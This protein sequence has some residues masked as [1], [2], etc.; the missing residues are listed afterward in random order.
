MHVTD[1]LDPLR[2]RM[3]RRV[4]GPWHVVDE[5]RLLGINRRNA[6]HV[7]DRIVGHCRHQVPPRIVVV[8]VDWRGVAEQV[9]LPLVGVATDEAVKVIKAH[10][11]GPLVEWP[12]G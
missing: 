2:R 10:A 1:L 6:F 8:W 7:L 11:D 12:R 4:H 3:V 9:W 5:E